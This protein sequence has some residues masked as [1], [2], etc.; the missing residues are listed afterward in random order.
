MLLSTPAK[1][2]P[3]LH[4]L[5]SSPQL[6]F[7][8]NQNSFVNP[9]FSPS[10]SYKP[11]PLI[12]KPCENPQKSQTTI[13]FL[14]SQVERLLT[15]NRELNEIVRKF[16]QNGVQLHFQ[17][18][19]LEKQV[20]ALLQENEQLKVSAENREIPS[21][22]QAFYQEKQL[23]QQKIEEL[24]EKLTLIFQD[25][26][27]LA[28]VL[29]E[30]DQEFEKIRAISQREN[31]LRLEIQRKYENLLTQTRDSKAAGSENQEISQILQ[32]NQA[33][34]LRFQEKIEVLCEENEKLNRL[35]LQKSSILEDFEQ[36]IEILLGENEKLHTI[37]EEKLREFEESHEKN[38]VLLAEKN[39]LQCI[40]QEKNEAERH[41]KQKFEEIE[42]KIKVLFFNTQNFK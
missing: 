20:N 6:S 9:Y 33:I 21:E 12:K 23:L 29:K 25:N 16:Q 27:R 40:L 42:G 1:L 38:R 35:V 11:A 15:E 7:K 19:E 13:A 32:E 18:N 17:T 14:Q 4:S 28:A 36:K 30:K 24:H 8:I 2:L 26:D 3:S 34:S 39:K 31:A 41:W 37:I 5:P 22:I 10:T